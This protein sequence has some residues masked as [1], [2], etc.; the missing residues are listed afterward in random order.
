MSPDSDAPANEVDSTPDVAAPQV[1]TP[2][3]V[4][5]GKVSRK[6]IKRLKRG[7]GPL[8]EE[9]FDVLDEVV[10][11]LADDLVGSTLV[12]V[13]LIYERKPKQRRRTLE[14]PF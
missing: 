4:D 12:P 14:L 8:V 5:L 6:K 10:D 1:V 11:E 9:V 13:V 3:V 2:V 7:S